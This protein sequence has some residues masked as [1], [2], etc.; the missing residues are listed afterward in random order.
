MTQV[1]SLFSIGKKPLDTDVQLQR[2]GKQLIILL[3]QNLKKKRFW[4]GMAGGLVG[5]GF[6]F[7]LLLLSEEP[8]ILFWIV[9]GLI[10]LGILGFGIYSAFTQEGIIADGK[11]ISYVRKNFGRI[12]RRDNYPVADFRDINL[13]SQNSDDNNDLMDIVVSFNSGGFAF[14]SQLTDGE[15]NWLIGELFDYLETTKNEMVMVKKK[16]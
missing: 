7:R 6:A 10:F 4:L 15:Q 9:F 8:E 12:T 14:G 5:F 11:I 2:S 1:Q 16:C 13:V 3:P